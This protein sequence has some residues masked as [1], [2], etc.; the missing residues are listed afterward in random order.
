VI[1]VGGQD[2]K[3]LELDASGRLLGFAMNDKCAA[4]TGRFLEVIARVLE[5]RV[6]QLAEVGARATA[7]VEISS[8][9]T[10]FAESEVISHLAAGTAIPD[11]VA[12]IHA[13]VSSR[14]AGLARRINLASPVVMTGGV[15]RNA[16]VVAELSS[17]LGLAVTASPQCQ[18]VGALGAALY[19]QDM[20]WELGSS[21]QQLLAQER[22]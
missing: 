5:L 4:G 22:T 16:Q 18:I 14:F 8:T 1:D 17:R 21:P 15:A 3:A 7:P 9:C 11:V 20:A 12:G 6:D 13:S 2:A 19:A 10:V